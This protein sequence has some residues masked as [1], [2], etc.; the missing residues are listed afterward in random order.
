[1]SALTARNQKHTER[2]VNIVQQQCYTAHARLQTAWHD[3]HTRKKLTLYAGL[4]VMT[5]VWLAVTLTRR[6]RTRKRQLTTPPSTPNLE[7]RSPFQAPER[8][9]GGISSRLLAFMSLIQFVFSIN[10]LILSQ[11]GHRPPSAVQ[12]PLPTLRGL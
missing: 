12:P 7:R 4:A 1:M 2:L 8:K 9:P 11:Y 5:S 6:L 10:P 3:E